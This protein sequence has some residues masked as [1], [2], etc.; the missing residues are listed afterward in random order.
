MKIILTLVLLMTA[1][2]NFAADF[3][4]WRGDRS[5]TGY[6]DVEI[7]NK[8]SLIWK[9]NTGAGVSSTPV[10]Y[11]GMV[12]T[13]SAGGKFY[14]MDF[15]TGKIRWT[16]DAKSQIDSPALCVKGS[17]IF[18]TVEGAL[19]SLNASDGKINW[20]YVS[21]EKI[22]CSANFFE[23]G[24]KTRI[25]FGSYDNVFSCL[26]LLSGQK[27]WEYK[28]DNFINGSPSLINDLVL[29]G[30]CDAIVHAISTKNG[31]QSFAVNTGSYI[32]ASACVAS[33][34]I[35]IGN[36]D[37]RF[38]CI[39]MKEK[40]ILWEYSNPDDNAV[41]FSSAAYK[42]DRV[43]VGSRD[44]TL[45]CFEGTSTTKKRILWKFIAGG[46]IDFSPVICK[47]KV[48]VGSK[49]GFIYLL[50]IDT[51]KPVWKYEIGDSMNGSAFAYDGKFVFGSSDGY[52]YVFGK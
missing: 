10:V 7:G 51:G 6:F 23:D 12:Y 17:V 21:K 33:G 35:F 19:Y 50:G 9:F 47:D 37:N 52:I 45:Y 22:S 25:V 41:F 30:G 4:I 24:G 43:I 5:L 2:Q 14:C 42:D 32:A 15:L 29:F 44:S 26:D 27:V 28:T 16:F 20:K 31:R 39:G 1:Y 46:S 8:P 11:E 34:R 3:S 13:G 49:D 40:K 48:I 38:M 36:Y 18:G